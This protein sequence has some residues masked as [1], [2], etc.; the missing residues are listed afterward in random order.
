MA[1]VSSLEQWMRKRILGVGLLLWAVSVVAATP[2]PFLI[3]GDEVVSSKAFKWDA[4]KGRAVVVFLSSRC[5]CSQS[6]EKSLAG[7]AGEFPEFRFVGIVSNGDE[8]MDSIRSHFKEASLPFPVVRDGDQSLA[9]QLGALKTP[10]AYVFSEG[11]LVFQGGVDDSQVASKA[12]RHYLQTALTQVREGRQP[13]P[14]SARTLGCLIR[15]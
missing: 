13:T 5:P 12:A 14:D 6:H 10:H 15:R 2:V 7:L 3:Q 9:N 11:K 1:Y 8:P 4:S